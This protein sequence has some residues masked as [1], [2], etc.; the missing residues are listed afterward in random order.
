MLKDIKERDH[1]DSTRE[2]N[3][4]KKAEDAIELD[5]TGMSIEEVINSILK[6]IK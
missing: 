4:L 2:L 1:N 3:P 5:T 6:E